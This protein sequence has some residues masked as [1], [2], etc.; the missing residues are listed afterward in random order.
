VRY[1]RRAVCSLVEF[2]QEKSEQEEGKHK[3]DEQ[4]GCEQERQAGGIRKDCKRE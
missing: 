4:E 1:R 2:E 3:K